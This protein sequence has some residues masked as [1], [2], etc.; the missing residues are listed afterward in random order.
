M[1]QPGNGLSFSFRRIWEYGYAALGRQDRII[2]IFTTSLDI[3]S[4]AGPGP[5]V[6]VPSRPLPRSPTLVKDDKALAQPPS[7]LAGRLI[8]IIVLL[9]LPPFS[10]GPARHG[11]CDCICMGCHS[12][13]LGNVSL[14]AV[15]AWSSRGCRGFAALAVPSWT[16]I[17]YM[18]ACYIYTY[19]T[20][21]YS[22]VSGRHETSCS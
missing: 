5:N 21:R 8:F 1:R 17:V 18:R 22:Q 15:P 11:A 13:A 3:L 10:S 19:T 4:H 16:S 9:V 2:I 20:R 7:D 14:R 6:F 12:Y